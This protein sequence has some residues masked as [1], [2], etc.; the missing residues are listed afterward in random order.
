MTWPNLVITGASGFVGRHL[1]GAIQDD[2]RIFGIARRSQ[3]RSGVA[4]HPNLI[5]FQA[6][7]AERAQIEPVFRR[8]REEGGADTVVHLAADRDAFGGAS[9]AQWRT[10]VIGLRHVLELSAWLPAR[11]FVFAS[12]VAACRIPRPG[13]AVTEGS[14]PHARDI[15]AV[16]KREGEAM[17]FEFSDRIHSVIARFAA[18][19]SDW[20]EHP[21]LSAALDRWLSNA[22]LRTSLHG[23]GRS[24]VPYLHIGDLVL[25][26]QEVLRSIEGL[27]P[28]EVLLASPDGAVSERELYEAATLA[29]FGAR[30]RSLAMP[31]AVRGALAW[32]EALIA[33]LSVRP[34]FGRTWM[35]DPVDGVL[36]VDARQTRRRLE[37]APRPRLE[38]LRRMPFLIENRKIDPAKWAEMNRTA[39]AELPIPASLKIYWLLEQHQER[40]I[41]D[42]NDLLTGPLRQARFSRYRALTSA[43]HEWNHRVV[44]RQLMNAVRTEDR[45]VFM[46][47]CQD[48][49]NQRCKEGFAANEVC[50]A[51]EALNLVCWRVLRLDPES[52][53]LRQPIFD[54]ITSTL[55]SGCDQVQE[56]FEVLQLRDRR[57]R[58][59]AERK[60]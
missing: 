41:R 6:D 19:F 31:G 37:W 16:T 39:V 18:P 48:L 30:G 23:H 14:P 13:M 54:T 4:L 51:L 15:G 52:K 43:Q 22:W 47:Y 5:W 59:Q 46:A 53:G 25:F 1:I 49:A 55:R 24:A 58:A 57:A 34:P 11:H 27:K 36:A 60:G 38:I 32:A 3:G 21:P 7:I 12:S 42:F 40:I 56:A 44:L 28:C 26:L 17:V 33:R 50:G 45:G 10:N 8:I 2:H 20:C 9:S 29:H 35:T